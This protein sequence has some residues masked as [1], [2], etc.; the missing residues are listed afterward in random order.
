MLSVLCKKGEDPESRHK[1]ARINR[2]ADTMLDRHVQRQDC[3]RPENNQ[4]PKPNRKVR[5]E[6]LLLSRADAAFTLGC[7]SRTIDYWIKKG[8]L[9]AVKLGRKRVGIP[10]PEVQR[11]ARQGLQDG[12]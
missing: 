11:I 5:P 12:R 9:K 8:L 6:R 2:K 4:E 10:F 1:E 7:S 3:H